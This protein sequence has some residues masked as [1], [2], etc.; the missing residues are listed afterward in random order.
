MPPDVPPVDEPLPREDEP[1]PPVVPEDPPVLMP[2]EPEDPDA[3]DSRCRQA[4]RCWPV[5]PAHALPVLDPD[6]GPMP[7]DEPLLPP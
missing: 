7:L 3:L 5:R 2:E 4:V 6:D 1:L